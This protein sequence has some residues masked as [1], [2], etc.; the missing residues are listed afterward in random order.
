VPEYHGP[1]PPGDVV[2][3]AANPTVAQ[4]LTGADPARVRDIARTASHPGE[5]PPAAELV[6][7]VGAV[8]GIEGAGHG[9]AGALAALEAPGGG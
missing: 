1:L 8:L 4:R 9:Y 2:A 7:A 3:L 5:L 6:A